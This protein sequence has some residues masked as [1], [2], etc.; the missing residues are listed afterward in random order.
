MNS[1]K[2]I[3]K[4]FLSYQQTV[5]QYKLVWIFFIDQASET[6]IKE[7]K[8]TVK[9]LETQAEN[10]RREL[11]EQNT[12]KSNISKNVESLLSYYQNSKTDLKTFETKIQNR[13][14]QL[15]SIVNKGDYNRFKCYL[16]TPK[17]MI[18]IRKKSTLKC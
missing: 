13:C 3:Q 12:D 6:Q 14:S 10:L 4:Q 11:L 18:I 7:L 17:Q 2:A 8:T 5:N 16:E 9:G 15:E 1:L